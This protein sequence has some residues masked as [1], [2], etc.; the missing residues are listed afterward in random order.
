MTRSR[1]LAGFLITHMF[2]LLFI[3]LESTKA[4]MGYYML[5]GVCAFCFKGQ[6]LI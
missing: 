5:L 3:C 6:G 4:A 1:S 2:I